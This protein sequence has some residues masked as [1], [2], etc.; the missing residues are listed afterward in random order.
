[1]TVLMADPPLPIFVIS[2]NR[3]EYLKSVIESYRRQ[4]VAVDIVVHDN[5]SDDRQTLDIVRGLSSEGVK[6]HGYGPI[7]HPDELNNVDVTVQRYVAETGYRGAYVV[8]DCDIDLSGAQPDALRLYLELLNLFHDVECVGPMLTIADIPRSYPLFNRVMS[9]HIAQFWGRQPE[10]A[11]VRAG[12]IAYLKHRIDTTFAV[13][14]AGSTFRRLKEGI[15]VYHPFEAKHLDWYV[16]SQDQ[17][18][19]RATSSPAISHWDN[20]SEFLKYQDMPDAVLNYTIVEGRMGDLRTVA[21]S[22]LDNPS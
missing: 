15:R 12:R 13:H 10:W 1:M 7:S 11:E 19:Y 21:R 4:D 17:S 22:T 16:S 14:R 9:R 20:D 5:G 3:G 8:T 2:F 18:G 6:I